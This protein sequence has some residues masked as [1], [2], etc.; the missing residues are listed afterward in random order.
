MGNCY[1]I[2]HIS[3][4]LIHIDITCNIEESQQKYRLGTVS[5]RLLGLKHVLPDPNLLQ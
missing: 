5:N 1:L 4:D 2:D 3:E